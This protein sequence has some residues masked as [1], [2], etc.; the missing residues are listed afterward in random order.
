LPDA[1]KVVSLIFNVLFT[2]DLAIRWSAEGFCAFVKSEEMTWNV[3]DIIIVATGLMDIVFFI[4][5]AAEESETSPSVTS[6]ARVLRIIR[7]AKIARII[8]VLKFFRELRMMIFSILNSMLS[9]IWVMLVLSLLFYIFGIVFTNGVISTLNT[10]EKW[11]EEDNADLIKYFGTLYRSIMSLFMAMTGGKDWGLFFASLE[12]VSWFHQLFFLGFLVFSLF[13][14]VNIVTGVFVDSAMTASSSDNAMMIQ[15][16]IAK[17]QA[18]LSQLREAFE[19]LDMEGDGIFDADEFEERLRDER[20][21]AYFQ[22]MKLD[23][24]EAQTI[25]RL[26]DKDN[27]NSISIEEFVEG[28]ASLMGEASSLDSKIMHFELMY[29]K[30]QISAVR[31]ILSTGNSKSSP[32]GQG[33]KSKPKADRN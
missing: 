23:V 1:L 13:A 5:S 15:E 18:L 3:F 22:S 20:V 6:V 12:L 28:I 17:K 2:L 21:S 30:E 7:V 16:E 14:V 27:S 24:K 4:M 31:D 25:F 8:R 9:L 10:P 33:S 19:D 29:V 32:K 11:L 26:L